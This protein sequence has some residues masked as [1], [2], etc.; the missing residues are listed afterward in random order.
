MDK[1]VNR[2]QNLS[3]ENDE[4]Q[5]L[6]HKKDKEQVSELIEAEEKET[7]HKKYKEQVS[8]PIEAEEKET[9][10]KKDKEQV[11]QPI[12]AEEKET[13][14][15]KDKEQVSQPIEAEEK[16]TEHKKDKEQVPE[17]IEGEE[18]EREYK[19]DKEQ[20]K[21]DE[22]LVPE[23]LEE[24]TYFD[25]DNNESGE[26]SVNNE[27]ISDLVTKETNRNVHSDEKAVECKNGMVKEDNMEADVFC[28]S[29][30][31][32]S[33]SGNASS[34]ETV[35]VNDEKTILTYDSKESS[36]GVCMN[37][38]ISTITNSKHVI[39]STDDVLKAEVDDMSDVKLSQ[40]KE[41]VDITKVTDGKVSDMSSVII[42]NAKLE[43]DCK[44]DDR[45]DIVMTQ[46]PQCVKTEERDQS[47]GA[48]SGNGCQDQLSTS[49]NIHTPEK[50]LNVGKLKLESDSSM[51]ENL[52]LKTP[53]LET[54]HGVQEGMN[55]PAT[56]QFQCIT[57]AMMEEEEKY[58][59]EEAENLNVV[60]EKVVFYTTYRCLSNLCQC[61][62]V[63]SPQAF[64][65][66]SSLFSSL[67]IMFH[68]KCYYKAELKITENITC[69]GEMFDHRFML[70]SL[71]LC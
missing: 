22:E 66:F 70:C 51:K 1:S 2:G 44:D 62:T 60:R 7:E 53:L 56:P 54:P 46:E 49:E 17:L 47:S 8:Q 31:N 59:R 26:S 20:M 5:V 12:E 3:H 55:S 42:E 13:E 57:Q 65:N 52:I 45:S 28:S 61:Y 11:S 50:H 21:N 30:N 58:K 10:H 32:E 71:N 25:A 40:D 4:E 15:K 6:E 27:I 63:F 43:I 41:N 38:I 9:E 39:D 64:L 67:C 34:G 23:E 24:S 37:E 14:H 48:A 29:T 35:C 33:N 18:K 19:K 69:G 16:E 68:L 36:P